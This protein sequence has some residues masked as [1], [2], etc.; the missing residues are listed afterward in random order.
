MEPVHAGHGRSR[1]ER[2]QVLLNVYV[3]KSR[4]L[5]RMK[6]LI[7]LSAVLAVPAAL[8]LSL[9]V[10]T[11][12]CGTTSGSNTNA[13]YS[14]PIIGTNGI[15]TTAID[16]TLS[17]GATFG[18]GQA[19]S[20]SPQH[21]P[22]IKADLQ[23]VVAALT[24]LQGGASTLTPAQVTTALGGL[25]LSTTE[26]QVLLPQFTALF[27]DALASLAAQNVN[28][29]PYMPKLLTALITGINSGLGLSAA[30]PAA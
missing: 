28:T 10:G 3:S 13:I 20:H 7:A 24:A 12:G 16:T 19:L 4:Y 1:P 29:G 5:G 11:V 27:N 26:V 22:Q 25:K 21:A 30:I 18:I 23:I 14:S 6:K 17:I 2:G 15:V 8:L 9:S